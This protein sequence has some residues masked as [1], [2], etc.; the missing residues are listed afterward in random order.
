MDVLQFTSRKKE[1]YNVQLNYSTLWECAL[2]IAAITNTPI[3]QTLEKSEHY[4]DSLKQSMSTQLLEQ[5]EFVEEHNT[6]KA[7]LQ[8]L[9]QKSFSQLSDFTSFI[10]HLKEE[11]FR[12]ICLP[13]VGNEYQDIRK[14]AAVHD[15]DAIDQLA[16]ATKDNPF[17]PDYIKFIT[18]VKTT[19]LKDHL[20]HLMMNWYE[21]V[22]KD[23]L[24]LTY[25][26]LKSDYESKV[27]MKEKLTSEQLVEWATGGIT[28]DPEPNVHTV[29]LIPQYIYRPW[30]I[31]AD[32][33]GTKV[34]YYPVSNESV[35]PNDR[36]M[37]NAFLVQKY[38][39][40]GDETRLK[41]VKQLFEKDRTL[42]YLTEQLEIGKSTVH[43]HLQILRAAKLVDTIDSRYI[44]KKHGIE[45]LFEELNTYLN[46]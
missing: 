6:W 30:N 21:E 11:E 17:F 43:H 38:K 41:I 25:R 13:Y 22:M 46:E 27:K 18:H 7:L 36:Y 9:H 29:L 1:T 3:I 16:D 12:F 26:I 20:I 39:A 44:L 14:K 15:E 32:I 33:E 31:E 19:Q 24:D 10:S 4:W 40:L 42:Q 2:G 34:F 8:L 37:P 45:V 28:Y 23:N 35:F 5:L